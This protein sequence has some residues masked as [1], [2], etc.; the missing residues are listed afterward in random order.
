MK[1]QIDRRKLNVKPAHK[2]ALLRNQA[3]HLITYGFLVSTKVRVKEVQRFVEKLITVARV[4]NDFN[5]RR[6]AQAI[7]PYKQDT[8]L[9]LFT[10]I[11]PKYA[12]RPGGYTRVIPMGQRKSDTATIAR[13]EWV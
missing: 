3:I 4:G 8:L 1:H 5:S 7:L 9:K 10:D 2:K 12:Q 11:A 6:R 13:L